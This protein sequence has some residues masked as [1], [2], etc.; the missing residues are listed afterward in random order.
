MFQL[1]LS[2]IFFSLVRN[3]ITSDPTL[4]IKITIN[5]EFKNFWEKDVVCCPHGGFP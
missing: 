1:Y 3:V 2:Q 4:N 5:N